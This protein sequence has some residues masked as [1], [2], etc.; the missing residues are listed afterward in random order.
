MKTAIVWFKT[1]LRLNDNETLISAI[2]QCESIIPVYCIDDAHFTKTTFGFQKT[3]AFRAQFLFESLVDLDK[4]L[5]ELG[6]GLTILQG[7]PAIEI[8][9]VVQKNKAQK[10]F[11]KKEVGDEEIKTHEAVEA[12][13]WK[14]QIPL[15]NV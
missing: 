13:L 6:S 11:T 8:P 9:K 10:V 3:G 5:R 12:A 1:D 14:M 2:A 7:N 15:E 4:N